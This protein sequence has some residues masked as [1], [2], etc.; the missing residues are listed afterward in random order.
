MRK[1]IFLALAISAAA[2]SLF[3]TTNFIRAASSPGMA[4]TGQVSSEEEGA[5]EGVLISARKAGST[6]TITVVSDEKGR[7]NFP[8]K[9]L[10]PGQYAIVVR[11]VGYEVDGAVAATIT[12]AQTATVDLKLRK[13]QDLAAQ[14]TNAEWLANVPGSDQQ[15]ST[16]LSCVGCHTVERIVRSKYDAAGFTQA[17]LPRMASYANQ[18]TPWRKPNG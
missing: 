4:L 6:V 13:A 15:K 17:I 12:P 9:K 2:V 1:K 3:F 8:S 11:A 5:M 14:L 16:L 18:S 10:E 7:Y